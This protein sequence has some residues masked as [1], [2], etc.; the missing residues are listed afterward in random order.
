VVKAGRLAAVTT[1]TAPTIETER[2]VL[3]AHR[4]CD[5]E[6]CFAMWADADVARF[7]GGSPS[8]SQE[9]WFR[10]LRYA[11][12]W[13]MVGFGYWAITDRDTGRFLGD[14][15]FAD[16]HRGMPELEGVPEVGWA[17]APHAWGRGIATEAVQAMLAWSDASLDV[18]EVRC[19]IGSTNVSSMRV[20]DKCGF[21]RLGDAV[22]GEERIGVFGRL[23]A[24]A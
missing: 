8:T 23:R 16:F 11:G 12:L 14:G 24:G 2:L 15:G 10:M 7:I 3:R 18:L 17:L 20:A 19:I 9:T 13:S 1:L 22:L 6:P 21:R 5:F 4:A